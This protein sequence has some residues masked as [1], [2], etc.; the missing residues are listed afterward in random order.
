MLSSVK[1][2]EV[3]DI[4]KRL[5]E[6]RGMNIWVFESTLSPCAWYSVGKLVA[7]AQ[8]WNRL[9]TCLKV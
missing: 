4:V 8:V 2:C 9:S 5:A 6:V 1:R 7:L 3:R